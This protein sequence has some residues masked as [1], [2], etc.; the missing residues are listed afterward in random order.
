MSMTQI[1]VNGVTIELKHMSV[2]IGKYNTGKS[3][4]L[5]A[6][7]KA[8]WKTVVCPENGIHRSEMESVV[9]SLR[10]RTPLG[11]PVAII[12]YCP[13]LLDFCNPE[14]VF[15]FRVVDDIREIINL[16]DFVKFEKSM[17]K[18]KLGEYWSFVGEDGL[19]DRARKTS[20]EEEVKNLQ[21]SVMELLYKE[22]SDVGE[23]AMDNSWNEKS[24]IQI[25]GIYF[26][27][28]EE[29]GIDTL[30]ISDALSEKFY[31]ANYNSTDNLINICGDSAAVD[32]RLD[33]PKSL[34][35]KWF[36]DA[37]VDFFISVTEENLRSNEV[38]AKSLECH[39]KDMRDNG[40]ESEHISEGFCHAHNE[41]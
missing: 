32:L 31:V 26:R 41:D 23:E 3:E 30:I 9:D 4:A 16:S 10:R 39:L 33:D 34:T 17:S 22:I 21:K 1:T 2:F 36:R 24:C 6:A 8:G 7:S 40:I 37:L 13:Y 27:L 38:R 5:K 25:N 20:D 35:W 14:E 12:T 18:P 19:I 29:R 15:V 11:P 28:V